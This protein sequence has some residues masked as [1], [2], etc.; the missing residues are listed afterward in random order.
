LSPTSSSTGA[1]TIT[2]MPSE[3]A[4]LDCEDCLECV[5]LDNCFEAS[6]NCASYPDCVTT[7]ACLSQCLFSGLCSEDCCDLV[8]AE[9]VAAA[10]ELYNCVLDVCVMN[11]EIVGAPMCGITQ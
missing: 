7:T 5:A 9:A 11:C 1:T 8:E 2:E 10:V 4:D 3:C 6:T